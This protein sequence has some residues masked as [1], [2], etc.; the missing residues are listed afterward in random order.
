MYLQMPGKLRRPDLGGMTLSAGQTRAFENVL[1]LLREDER[2]EWLG[3]QGLK[4]ALE[5]VVCEARAKPNESRLDQA[6]VEEYAG[7]PVDQTCFFPV[8]GLLVQAE[9]ELFGVKLL[10]GTAAQMPSRLQAFAQLA[11]ELPIQCVIAV[12][13]RGTSDTRMAARGRIVA[14]HALRLLR[15]TL[16]SP[17]KFADQQLRFQLGKVWWV[18]GGGH[19]AQMPTPEHPVRLTEALVVMAAEHSLAAVP[20]RDGDNI[21]EH[22]RIALEWFEKAQLTSDR[23]SKLLYLFFALEAFL[24]DESDGLKGENL[25]LR[26][27]VLSHLMTGSMRHPLRTYTLYGQVRSKAVHGSKIAK[28]VTEEDVDGFSSD[29]RDGLDD[30]VRFARHTRLTKRSQVIRVLDN[31]DARTKLAA[32]LYA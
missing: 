11:R 30:F 22:V 10:P 2:F 7:E 28:P 19:H 24:G 17:M 13:V 32:Q 6:F 25:T 9:T 16:R 18:D 26:R 21:D 5:Y 20:A 29:L 1:E 4:D 14:E 31:D 12:P 23:I 27:A 15:I 8:R 3:P